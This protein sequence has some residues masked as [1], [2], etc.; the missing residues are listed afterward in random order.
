MAY[1]PQADRGFPLSVIHFAA[2]ALAAVLLAGIVAM[3]TL[4]PFGFG[5]GV[6]SPIQLSPAV[7]ESGRQWELERLQQL[8]YVDPLVEDGRDWERERRQQTPR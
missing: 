5:A 1:A 3:A 6:D 2:A 7:L 4:D 8:G